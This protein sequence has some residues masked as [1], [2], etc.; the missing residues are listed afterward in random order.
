MSDMFYDSMPMKIEKCP[1]GCEEAYMLQSVSGEI[2]MR[3]STKYGYIDTEV[4]QTDMYEGVIAKDKWKY[5]R[6][7]NCDRPLRAKS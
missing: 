1:C 2:E 5:W 6:C 4:D 3:A 7:N